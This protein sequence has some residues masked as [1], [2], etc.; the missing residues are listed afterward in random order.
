VTDNQSA[1]VTTWVQTTDQFTALGEFDNRNAYN[2]VLE[3][4]LGDLV[5]HRFDFT[6]ETAKISMEDQRQFLVD[7]ICKR[8]AILWNALPAE[9]GAS[10]PAS[11]TF[12]VI[13]NAGI[14]DAMSGG[15]IT[16]R[17]EEL[18]DIEAAFVSGIDD[19]FEE[20]VQ[21][22]IEQVEAE[23]V[24]DVADGVDDTVEKVGN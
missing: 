22:A 19:A 17:L 9:P 16:R 24:L 3:W 4:D 5:L 21:N 1:G 15:M 11:Q 14:L 7:D 12:E 13:E 6:I 23:E 2:G 20:T 18:K 10:L 8:Y